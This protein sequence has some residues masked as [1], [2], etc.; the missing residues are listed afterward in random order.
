MTAHASRTSD[1]TR[2]DDR[3][4][5]DIDVLR[6]LVGDDPDAVREFLVEFLRSARVQVDEILASLDA[7][8]LSRVGSVAHKLKASSRSVGALALGERCAEVERASHRDDGDDV[9]EGCLHM[10]NAMRDA[11]AFISRHLADA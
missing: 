3:P 1:T 6:D 11:E 10:A 4:L 9:A 8:D 2:A 7:G 5:V